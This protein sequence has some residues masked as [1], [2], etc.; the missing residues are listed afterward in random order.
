MKEFLKIGE[1]IHFKENID[2]LDYSLESGQ[3]YT[4]CVDSYEDKVWLR[5]TPTFSMPKK[6][7]STET[8]T[9]FKN[10]ILNRFNNMKSGSLGV[11][12]EG[13]KGSGKTITAKDI[14]LS[15]KLPIIIINKYLHPSDLKKVV[16]GLVETD[17]CI[18][19]DE[20]D[21]VSEKY[22]SNELLSILDGLHTCGKKLY[23]MT[24]NT[25]ENINEYMKDR[26]SRIRYWKTFEQ[27]PKE[28]IQ[29]IAKDI[30][31]VDR[32]EEV[33]DFIYENISC[34]SFD[35]VFSFI[36]EVNDNKDIDLQ[37]LFK[38]MNLTP[39]KED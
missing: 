14:A 26:C 15:S 20:I 18:L 39:H 2:G 37:T 24:C 19:F 36:E 3:I 16:K 21:K 32:I 31:T 6:V 9:M 23:I 35:N 5:L 7:Y 1:N 25:N 38:D 13:L 33:V 4:V 34:L 8:D 28:T 29:L 11:M 10:R 12:L 17:V 22:D 27:T 30:L